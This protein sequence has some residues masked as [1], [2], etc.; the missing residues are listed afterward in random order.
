M[1]ATAFLRLA[2]VSALFLGA[3]GRTAVLGGAE[4]ADGGAGLDGAVDGG[5]PP[6]DG[7]P[8][9]FGPFDMGDPGDAGGPVE[10]VGLSL[11]PPLAVLPVAGVAELSA[12][13]L[14]SDGGSED[15]SA[16]ALWTSDAP[17]VASV[18]AGRVVGLAPGV[19]RIEASALGFVA[20]AEV[21][22]L[23][24]SPVALTVL[25]PSA[26][27]AVDG[28]ASFGAELAL[29]DGSVIDVTAAASWTTDD[30]AVAVVTGAG[31]AQGAG[32]GEA[33]ITA[34]FEGLEASAVLE[35]AAAELL[36]IEVAPRDPTLALG[37]TQ[38]FT[39]LG[40]FDDGTT[41]DLGA[42]VVWASSDPAVLALEGGAVALAEALG[43]GT[44]IVS[45]RLGDVEGISTVTVTA[46]RL[47]GLF[48]TPGAVSV[49]VGDE[50]P[51]TLTGTFDDG[52]ELDLTESAAWF[53]ADDA[54]VAVGNAAGRRGVVTGLALGEVTVSASFDGRTAEATVT[55]GEAPLVTLAIGPASATIPAGA[56]IAFTATGTF[57][58]GTTR[59]VTSLVRW[60]VDDVSVALV[61]SSG[62]AAGT[63]SAVA[64]GTTTLRAALEGMEATAALTVTEASL[65]RITVTPEAET[66]TAGLRTFYTATG[67]FSDGAVADLSS[68]VVWSTVDADV[69]TISNAT[70]AEGQLTAVAAG[71]T[72]VE[73]ATGGVVGSTTVTVEGPRL[74]EVQVSPVSF[75]AEIGR[76]LQY[77]A[78]AVFSNGDRQNVTGRASWSS[79]ASAV[80]TVDGRGRVSAVGAGTATLTATFDGLSGSGTITVSDASVVEVQVSP[81]APALAAGQ[82]LRF[83]AVAIFS[84]GTSRNVTNEATWSSSATAT[85]TVSNDPRQR[86][87]GTAVAEGT[88]DAIAVFDGVTGRQTVTVTAATVVDLSVDPAVWSAAV[89]E[90]RRFQAVAIFSDGSSRNVTAQATWTSTAASVAQVSNRP[91]QQGLVTALAAGTTTLRATFEGVSGEATVTISAATVDAVQVTPFAPTLAVG[92]TQR[93]QAVALFSD[94]TSRNVTNEVTWLSSDAAVASA[95]NAAGSRGLV[96][97]LA[98]G[99]STIEAVYLGTRG[100]TVLTVSA[101]TID[102]IQV[103]PFVPT[104]PAGFGAQMQATAIFTD[105]ST[106]DVTALATWTSSNAVAA[107]V[108]NAFGSQGRLLALAAGSG[109]VAAAYLGVS[110]ST[111]FTITGATLSS[112]AVTPGTASV[113]VGGSTPFEAT[114][115]FS[116]G[117]TLDIGF[118]VTWGSSNLAVADVSNAAGSRGEATGFAAG[119]AQVTA[120]NGGVTGT[121]MLTVTP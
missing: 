33:T 89:G 56:E 81:V 111:R 103:T 62:G 55:V 28:T 15:V 84:D 112:I 8:A 42:S 71:T 96:T 12:I 78:V 92:S 75:S 115:T 48:I 30:E 45:A 98:A 113:A 58:D 88:A 93:F 65:V 11:E 72:T 5:T 99:T 20:Q 40:V 108:S 61:A 35:V 90:D 91:G 87:L 117:S 27:T 85:L 29:D 50:L 10:V 76:N 46:A 1:R 66:T 38:A 70:G 36:R 44:S 19:A 83:Q 104:L 64:E 18:V 79:S 4:D 53:S 102:R 9:D 69:A 114:G 37:G 39:A 121:A 41:A 95:S 77:T 63:V 116:D 82:A 74:I 51:L 6:V 107:S 67:T 119:T 13:A 22:V 47:T 21:E 109:D 43:A 80:A 59:D 120:R 52:S 57:A 14:R 34:R 86:G 25:P 110:G 2:C 16:T 94:G 31:L 32:P 23:A 106:R 105:G 118:F 60:T 100:S 17:D 7:S 54:I 73:A 26:R 49:G 68:L 101:A 24:A 3:C 97:A